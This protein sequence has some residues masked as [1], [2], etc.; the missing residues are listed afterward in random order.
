MK[1]KKIGLAVCCPDSYRE[2]KN[3]KFN[4]YKLLSI[5]INNYQLIDMIS[6]HNKFFF[7]S[8]GKGTDQ[9]IKNC[10]RRFSK[11]EF[12]VNLHKHIS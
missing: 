8:L 11:K 9:N 7:I 6:K 12:K 10:I 3:I 2:Y 4:F 5:A 1:N